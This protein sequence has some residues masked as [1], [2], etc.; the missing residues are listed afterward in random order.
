MFV[1]VN[2]RRSSEGIK[3][4]QIFMVKKGTVYSLRLREAAWKQ[5]ASHGSRHEKTSVR[6]ECLF[7]FN[8]SPSLD[9]PCKKDVAS[10]K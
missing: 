9:L 3:P 4:H 6:Q 8:G 2:P 10:R 1:N 5:L 7:C